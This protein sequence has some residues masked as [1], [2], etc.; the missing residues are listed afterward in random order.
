MCRTRELSSLGFLLLVPLGELNELEAVLGGETLVFLGVQHLPGRRELDARRRLAH[1]LVEDLETCR[2]RDLQE[3]AFGLE[4][5]PVRDVTRQPEERPRLSGHRL[6]AARAGDPALEQVPTL[7]LFVMNVE[8]RLSRRRL[9]VEQAQGAA[10][11]VA[12]RLD[13]HQD[14]EVPDR[15]AALSIQREELVRHQSTSSVSGT[16]SGHLRATEGR[17]EVR[18]EL[19]ERAGF[20]AG[21]VLKI[22]RDEVSPP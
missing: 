11:L 21:D 14:L 20:V 7:V 1:L 4:A 9:E 13:R 22:C 10:G 16:R 12:A 19:F 2:D 18:R 8:G 5:Q 6:V 17:R 3:M 15:I